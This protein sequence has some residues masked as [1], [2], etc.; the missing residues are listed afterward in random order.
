MHRAL[1]RQVRACR[2]MLRW[3]G[4][5][6]LIACLTMQASFVPLS[7]GGFHACGLTPGG[8]VY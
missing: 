2:L 1:S 6:V 4:A 7:V 5:T 3:Y 8:E